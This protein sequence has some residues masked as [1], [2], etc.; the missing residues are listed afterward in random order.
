MQCS[1]RSVGGTGD[2]VRVPIPIDVGQGDRGDSPPEGVRRQSRDGASVHELEGREDGFRLQHRQGKL[3]AEGEVHV[4]DH[5][6]LRT[7]QFAVARLVGPRR[8]KKVSKLIEGRGGARRI[9]APKQ[10]EGLVESFCYSDRESRELLTQALE[11]TGC[12][13]GPVSHD[14]GG[15][16]GE[17][18]CE[19]CRGSLNEVR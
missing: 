8:H 6:T 11:S 15:C 18:R 10:H 12:P 2:E 19:I 4:A 1:P 14:E 3:V 17:P 9:S 7:S 5:G 13:V 16:Q